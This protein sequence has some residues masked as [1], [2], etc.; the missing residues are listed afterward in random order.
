MGI[1]SQYALRFREIGNRV[2][3]DVVL[4][5]QSRALRGVLYSDGKE[6]EVVHETLEKITGSSGF[7]LLSDMGDV[8]R[9]DTFLEVSVTHLISSCHVRKPNG[10][11]GL[12]GILKP[13]F[14]TH[15][16]GKFCVYPPFLQI[17][18]ER[19]G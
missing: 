16:L 9:G 6:R 11:I 4:H 5:I 3:Y 17:D 14:L 2:E 10:K 12:V 18:D 15:S 7:S 1:G 19:R 13:K 8:L